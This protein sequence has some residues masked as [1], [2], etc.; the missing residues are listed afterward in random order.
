MK[1]N[2]AIRNQFL[3]I[4]NTQNILTPVNQYDF[5]TANISIQEEKDDGF[6]GSVTIDKPDLPNNITEIKK[7][8]VSQKTDKG[9]PE[10]GFSKELLESL[11]KLPPKDNIRIYLVHGSH[12]GGHRSAAESLKAAMDE[13]PHVEAEVINAL[14]YS[15]KG[16]KN[17]QVG[18]TQFAI[19]HMKDLRGWCFEQSHKGNPIMYWLGNL[20]MKIKGFFSKKFLTKIKEEKPDAIIAT[21]SPMNSMLSSWKTAGKIDTPLLSTVTDFSTHRMWSQKGVDHYYTAS[22]AAAKDLER[23]KVNGD[24]IS[25]TGIPIKPSFS[26][27]SSI[28]PAKMKEK[29]GLDPHKPVVLLMGGSL[30][31]GPYEELSSEFEKLDSPLQIVAIC[32]KNKDKLEILEKKKDTMKQKLVPL[33]FIKNVNEYMQAADVIISKPGG[34]TAS[35]IFAM[36]KPM[37]MLEPMPGLEEISATA[38]QKLGVAFMEKTP[39]GAAKFAGKLITTPSLMKDVHEKL[40]KVGHPDS[41]YAVA[42]DVLKRALDYHNRQG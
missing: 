31:Y 1:I 22:A 17:A 27:V 23:F 39:E 16:L 9:E 21:H 40:N 19:D 10:I 20:G 7:K 30:G 33:G 2:N 28:A 26:E 34:L 37:I 3:N 13:L 29:L 14:D 12:T 32:G 36:K 25:V 11:E 6:V 15:G 41:S 38:I 8:E 18:A 5:N 35:E 42:E 4:K 24:K